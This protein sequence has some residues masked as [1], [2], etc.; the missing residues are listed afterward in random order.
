M[1]TQEDEVKRLVRYLK[2]LDFLHKKE[3]TS[4]KSV[5]TMV[6]RYVVGQGDKKI[7]NHQ[8]LAEQMLD[9]G[10]YKKVVEFAEELIQDPPTHDTFMDL[11]REETGTREALVKDYMQSVPK[12][13]LQSSKSTLNDLIRFFKTAS[14]EVR[15]FMVVDDSDSSLKGIVSVNDFTRNLD[16]V[17]TADKGTLVVNLKFY[18]GT[19]KVILDT[20]KM[21][22]AANLFYEAQQAGKK[23]TKL[24]VV[25][26]HKR[27]VG[28]LA[29]PDLA[30][31][32]AVSI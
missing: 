6:N 26:S 18:N 19:P 22:Y 31:W 15:Y 2:A 7:R 9:Y 24:L 25:N 5:L 27:P 21:D 13:H 12:G 23:I 4:V 32:E 11:C 14:P 30:R 20:D 29:E 16:E 10:V 28:F 8:D 3:S 17:K 1:S